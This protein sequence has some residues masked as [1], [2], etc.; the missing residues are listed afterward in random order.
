MCSKCQQAIY[1]ILNGTDISYK[2]CLFQLL[3]IAFLAT[4]MVID[5][6][7]KYFV[8][9]VPD[10][11]GENISRGKVVYFMSM[12]L[13]CVCVSVC[14]R[15]VCIV[16]H[17]FQLEN[18]VLQVMLAKQ[19]FAIVYLGFAESKRQNLILPGEKPCAY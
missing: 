17:V 8:H 16:N 5:I 14:V 3:F 4:W 13:V 11:T 12:N 15:V 2:F 6:I 9:S 1:H 19:C 7:I 10:I 18:I